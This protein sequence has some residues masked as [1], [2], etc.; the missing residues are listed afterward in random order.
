MASTELPPA[1]TESAT[2][3]PV[4]LWRNRD[5]LLLWSGQLI[6]E[7]GSTASRLAFP[8]LML[9]LT[10]SPAQA[11][12]LGAANGL[13]YVFLC[14]PAGAYID[15]WNRKRV[16]ILCDVVRALALGSIPLAYELRVL[17]LAQLYVVAVIEGTLFTFFNL[18]DTAAL[19]QVVAKEQLPAATAQSQITYSLS[20]LLG[21]T[22]AGALYGVGRVLPFLADAVSYMVSFVSLFFIKTQFQEERQA[23]ERRL[24]RE[25]QEGIV[26]LWRNPLIRFICL[27]TGGL[28]LTQSGFTLIIILLAQRFQATSFEIGLILAA[29]G[30]GGLIGAFAAPPIRRRVSF[31]QMLTG[32]M[33]L[34]TLLWPLLALA[35][36]LL[37]LG[38]AIFVLFVAIPAYD[39]TQFSYRIALIP[40][41]LQG[42]VNSVFRLIAVGA[43]PA[44][45]ALTGVL[46]Q[47]LGPV[48]TVWVLFFPQVV[49]SL[50]TTLNRHVQQ[51]PPIEQARHALSGE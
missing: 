15:R 36:S 19:P 26:W 9:F 1:L 41:A 16:M 50:A 13:P 20:D 47:W 10:G 38:G 45:L 18:A 30:I 40:D 27:L 49:L 43:R 6:S 17:S 31:G 7:L 51:A 28:N 5:Y 48:E 8:L 39:I 35:P 2:P 37:L 21:P 24:W 44:C 25:I 23:T 29:G 32:V 14:L 33:W 12:L 22:L 11:G 3:R 34:F 4:P 46:L 42:R